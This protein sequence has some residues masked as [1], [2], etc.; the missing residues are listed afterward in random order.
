VGL[1]VLTADSRARS[2]RPNIVFILADDVVSLN[3][4][5]FYSSHRGSQRTEGKSRS[6]IPTEKQTV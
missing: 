3:M 1:L 5:N 4:N 6:D 2:S